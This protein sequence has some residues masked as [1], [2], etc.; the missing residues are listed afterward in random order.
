MRCTQG[1]EAVK[2][3]NRQPL[4]HSERAFS[5]HEALVTLAVV[6]TLT[7]I[8]VPSL[9]QFVSNQRMTGAI[10]SLITALHLARSEAIKRNENVA[11]CPSVDGRNCLNTDASETAW[12][13]GYLLYVDR[14]ENDNP[15][16]DE[17]VVHIFGPSSGLR[18]RSSS[19]RNH[20]TYRSNGLATG[21]N[22]SFTFCTTNN[23]S[24]PRTV[25]V[26]NSG[27]VRTSSKRA[28]GSLI[29]CSN[30]V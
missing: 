10:N 23:T 2:N 24:P 26:A 6:S 9:Q 4:F 17:A 22:L 28:D 29:I 18:I 19:G 20:V 8:A 11:L 1:S 5:L 14:N 7:T 16:A 30:S 15:D 25:I 3:P 13:N 27:R 21:S 12:E